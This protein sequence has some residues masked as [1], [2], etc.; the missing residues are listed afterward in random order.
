MTNLS[1]LA[2]V[3]GVGMPLATGALYLASEVGSANTRIEHLVEKIDSQSERINK[4]TEYVLHRLDTITDPTEERRQEP[5]I[6]P[7]Y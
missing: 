7:E 2:A 1:T 5:Y 4:L 6:N 3:L